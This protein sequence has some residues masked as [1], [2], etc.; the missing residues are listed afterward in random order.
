MRASKEG[1]FARAES[2]T[3][4]VE[5][6]CRGNEGKGGRASIK[7]SDLGVEKRE[8]RRVSRREDI[9]VGIQKK[10]EGGDEGIRS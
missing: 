8:E 3:G 6:E 10:E 2:A 1:A 4:N 5:M 7:G 9:V